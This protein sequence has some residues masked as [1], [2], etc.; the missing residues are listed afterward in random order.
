MSVF[1]AIYNQM[2]AKSVPILFPIGDKRYDL[3]SFIYANK[4]RLW[5]YQARIQGVGAGARAHP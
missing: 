3:V 4:S 2:R 5:C 1:H